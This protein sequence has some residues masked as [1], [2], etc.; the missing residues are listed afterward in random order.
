MSLARVEI[1]AEESIASV[2]IDGK[3]VSMEISE[4]VYRHKAGEIPTLTV[5][6][7]V[8]EAE[9]QAVGSVVVKKPRGSIDDLFG[10]GKETSV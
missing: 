2:M 10:R 7:L 6:Y 4:V 1:H 9:I 8:Q 3:D 5:T